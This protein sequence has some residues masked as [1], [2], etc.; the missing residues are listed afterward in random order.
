MG[1]PIL[2]LREAGVIEDG[3][4]EKGVAGI[5]LPEFDLYKKPDYLQTNEWKQLFNQW[6]S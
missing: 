5:Y 3:I 6:S 4:L 2:V 1:L